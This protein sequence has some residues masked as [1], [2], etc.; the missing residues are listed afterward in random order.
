MQLVRMSFFK[1]LKDN[2][3]EKYHK[4]L[5]DSDHSQNELVFVHNQNNNGGGD[6]NAGSPDAALIN[7]RLNSKETPANLRT[8]LDDQR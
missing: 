3:H 5:P 2:T 4:Y 7:D 8:L 1:R 6:E